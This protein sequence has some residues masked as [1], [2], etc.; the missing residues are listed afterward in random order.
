M[1]LTFS[2]AKGM[3]LFTPK[4]GATRPTSAK[5]RE[6]LMSML[7][8]WLQHANF[9][10][11]FSGSGGCGLDALSRGASSVVFVENSSDAIKCLKRNI[12]EA[13]RR[14]NNND[15]E[16]LDIQLMSQNAIKSMKV[17]KAR[18]AFDIVWAD[19]PYSLT[20]EWFNL[21]KEILRDLVATD[22]VFAMES[23][24]DIQNELNMDEKYWEHIKSKRYG[25]TS[26]NVWQRLEPSEGE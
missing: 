3:R 13:Q 17:L 23:S 25:L 7:R 9:I 11:L 16:E 21:S 18:G 15:L 20:L 4:G 2:W 1:K 24:S 26:I 19:P 10:D 5:N 6:S 8:P 12:E 22:G 14:A